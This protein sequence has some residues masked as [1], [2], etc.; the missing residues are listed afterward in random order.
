MCLLAVSPIP[1]RSFEITHQMQREYKNIRRNTPFVVFK[2]T[3]QLVLQPN[4]PAAR[5]LAF[6]KVFSPH[7]QVTYFPQAIGKPS[8]FINGQ[9][10]GL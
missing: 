7:L 8:L 5:T 1:C 4:A 9:L 6:A 2:S 10:P 3:T